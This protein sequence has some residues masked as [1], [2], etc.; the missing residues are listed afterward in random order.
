MFGA[1][2]CCCGCVSALEEN[3]ENFTFCVKRKG[4][5]KDCKTL[6]FGKMALFGN[7]TGV[8]EGLPLDASWPV[9]RSSFMGQICPHVD[10][11]VCGTPH[12]SPASI[13]LCQHWAAKCLPAVGLLVFPPFFS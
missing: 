12:L 6:C 10:T 8:G 7:S 4:L 2:G 3:E 5:L 1:G 13:A 9:Y 11:P